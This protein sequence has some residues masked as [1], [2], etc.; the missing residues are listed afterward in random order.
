[1]STTLSTSTSVPV[2]PIEEPVAR[3]P[4]PPAVEHLAE[5]VGD[6]VAYWGFK[7]IQGRIWCLMYLAGG[8]VDAG[9]LI[10]RLGAS[11]AHISTSLKELRRYRVIE[12]CG[13][14]P[15][16]TLLYRANPRLMDVILGVLR[17]REQAMMMR[18]QAAAGELGAMNDPA[19]RGGWIDPQRARQMVALIDTAGTLLRQVLQL[20]T[21]D[22]NALGAFNSDWASG[23]DPHN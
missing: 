10:E 4:L 6:F 20:G 18:I 12:P 17:G 3:E 14:S 21:L 11:K 1:M 22:V 15:R 23:D 2:P 9:W 8:P 19:L 5:Q 7:R 13:T 16:N